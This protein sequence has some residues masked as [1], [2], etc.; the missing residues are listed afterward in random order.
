MLN[1]K[2]YIGLDRRMIT[3]LGKMTSACEFLKSNIGQKTTLY[4]IHV[5]NKGNYCTNIIQLKGAETPAIL[6]R[7]FRQLTWLVTS[8]VISTIYRFGPHSL[9]QTFIKTLVSS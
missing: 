4:S 9:L 3:E 5:Y 7:D 8:P 6:L 2:D 1:T